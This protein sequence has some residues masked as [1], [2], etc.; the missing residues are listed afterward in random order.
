MKQIIHEIRNQP[1]H[2]RELAT[3]LCTIAVVAVV[4]LVWFR[5]FQKDIYALLNPSDE[6]QAQDQFF[7]QQSQSLFGSILSTLGSG[8]AQISAF[9]SGNGGESVIINNNNS[10]SGDSSTAPHP[11]P[12]SGNR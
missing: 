9:L 6:P 2:I 10:V 5:S 1:H 7:A 12:V 8:K 4:V 11:L 3:M